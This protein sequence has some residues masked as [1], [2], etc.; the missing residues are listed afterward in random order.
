M[1]MI[2][3]VTPALLAG[4]TIVMKPS[5]ET[6][7]EAYIM[8]SCAAEVGFPPGVLNLVT[9]DRDVSDHLVSNTLVDKVSFTGSTLAGRRIA[10]VCAERIAR[11]SLELGGKSAAIVAE[12]MSIEEAAKILAST[13]SMHSGQICQMLSRAIVPR[14]RHDELAQAIAHEMKSIKLGYS[15]DPTAQ[16]GPLAMKRQLERVEMYVEAGLNEGATL[17]SGGRRPPDLAPGYFYEPTLFSNVTNDM[18]ISREEIFGPVLSL[19]PCDD[20]D[21]GIRIANES[22]FGLN[23]SVLTHDPKEAYRIS[24]AMR[25]G[26]IGQNGLHV[27]FA[28]PF[29]GFKQS[30]IGREGDV[31]GLMSYLETK[32]ILIHTEGFEPAAAV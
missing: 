14:R 18:R 25:T 16:M 1:T 2:A 22:I 23:G 19:L 7:L 29:G 11:C 5:P 21:D 12:D 31:E 27:D 4:C 13:I 17:V 30:G 9:A 10:S 26:N 15:N 8:A 20:I 6:P 32:T 3:K 24:R 28:L